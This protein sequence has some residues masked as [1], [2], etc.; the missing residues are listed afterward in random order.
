MDPD[1]IRDLFA[2]FGPVTVRRM[3]SGAGLYRDGTIFA[4]V[5]DDVIYLKTDD[6][7]RGAFEEEG[8]RPFS[9][10]ARGER[11]VLT[12][13]WRMPDRLYDDPD[14]LVRWASAALEASRRAARTPKRARRKS[15]ANKN[16]PR[17]EA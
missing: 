15:G 13:Y 12:S 1:Y 3:F 11:R 9:Y 10:V 4:L 2:G 5:I 7:T 8:L 14:E 16:R 17:G 6:Q